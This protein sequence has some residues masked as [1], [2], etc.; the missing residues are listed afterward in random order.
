VLLAC[1]GVGWAVAIGSTFLIDHGDLFGLRQGWGAARGA[2]YRPPAFT[3]RSL[4][5]YVRHPLM[6]GF[7]IL[8]WSAPVMTGSHLLFAAAATV[9]IGAGIKFE[10]HDLKR[11]IGEPY[12]AYQAR[13]PAIC[14]V[15]R[16][17][18]S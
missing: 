16:R 17:R 14:P 11:A 6:A 7:V 9:Y 10:E 1:Y 5:R 2:E 8:F 18:S 4:Y 13:V 15:P 12:A 3:E